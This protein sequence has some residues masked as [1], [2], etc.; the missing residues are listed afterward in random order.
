MA[1]SY[2][3]RARG[4]VPVAVEVVHVGAEGAALT[5]GDECEVIGLARSDEVLVF[6]D[7]SAAREVLWGLDVLGG[8]SLRIGVQTEE[9][10]C[11]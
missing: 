1:R 10:E 5:T 8:W 6:V 3:D 4:V 2:R 9:Q 11:H 7:C